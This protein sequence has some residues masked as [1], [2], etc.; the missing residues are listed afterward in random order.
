MFILFFVIRIYIFTHLKTKLYHLRFYCVEKSYNEVRFLIFRKS[1]FHFLFKVLNHLYLIQSNSIQG[2]EEYARNF[3][4]YIT[5][6]KGNKNKSRESRA[7]SNS[8]R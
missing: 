1:W 8:I 5:R 6:D 7:T 3:S 2:G 4:A